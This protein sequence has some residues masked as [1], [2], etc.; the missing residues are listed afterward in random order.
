[1]ARCPDERL[2]G[3]LPSPSPRRLLI[4]GRPDPALKL[5]DRMAH[6]HLPGV[7]LAMAQ[8]GE[9]EQAVGF[10]VAGEGRPVTDQT[11]FQAGSI[12]KPVTAA[13]ALR[14]VD[15]G[16][17]D[18]DADVGKR[19]RAWNLPGHSSEQPVTLRRIL[20][21]NAGLSVTGFPGHQAGE[22]LPTAQDV[23]EGRPPANTEPVRVVAEP[24]TVVR[25][26]GGAFIIVQLL[27][28]EATGS[29]FTRAVEDLVFEPAGM[30]HSTFEQEF[31]PEF[32][33]DAS[34]GH[35]PDAMP[36]AGGHYSYPLAAGGL[37][38]TPSDLVRFALALCGAWSGRNCSSGNYGSTGNGALLSQEIA[39][40]MF[41][42]QA[43]IYGLGIRIERGGGNNWFWHTGGAEGFRAQM[44]SSL[45]DGR[46]A[47]IMSN[48]EDGMQ[49][50]RE[51]LEAI[52]GEIGR[53]DKERRV[54]RVVDVETAVRR[55]LRVPVRG[56]GA[57]SF[58]AI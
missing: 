20:S 12:S 23:L 48:G 17:L 34:L 2:A 15:E 3:T 31:P 39:K 47:V 36:V 24:G 13:A 22:R 33:R 46:V 52:Y 21:H 16:L 28:E 58:G 10:G 27:I 1:M 32:A 29:P 6:Y 11:L 19:L 49:L 30:A 53:L 26:S 41:S 40:A 8:G 5:S 54:A 50:T 35:R 51:V 4:E 18:L 38:T 37:W 7:S 56:L 44:R 25:Y 42:P 55:Q 9:L 14:L 45:E 57:R 43:G